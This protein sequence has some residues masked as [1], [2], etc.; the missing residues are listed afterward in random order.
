MTL[1]VV[2]GRALRVPDALPPEFSDEALALRFTA[3][4]RADLRHVA[5][6]GKW[7]IYQ[8]GQWRF[9][10][11]L[12][13]FSLARAICR[14]AAHGC[15]DRSAKAIASAKTVAAVEKLAKADRLH[16]AT[17]DQW[18]ADPWLL[19]T[20]GGVIDLRTG[21][22]QPHERQDYMTKITAA[23][24][25]GECPLWRA[26]LE[27][28]T[29]GD[30]EL[31]LFLQRVVGYALSGNTREH[32]LFFLY[33]T[34]ANGKSVFINTIAG[35]LGDYHTTA[36][37]DV[38]LES[39][40]KNDRHPTE[41]ACL[42]GARLVTATETEEGRRW[43][44]SRIKALTGGDRISAR[45]MRQDFFEFTPQFKLLVAGN[46]KPSLRSVDEAIRRRLHLIPFT[47]TIPKDE[48]DETLADK[49]KAE[50]PG[51]LAWAI[52]GGVEWGLQGLMPPEAVREATKQYLSAEDAMTLWIEECCKVDVD[53]TA[54]T[55]ELYKSWRQ[56]CDRTGE[57]AGSQKRFAQRLD[58][59]NYQRWRQGGT[60]RMGFWGLLPISEPDPGHS[61][62]WQ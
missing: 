50:W 7:L 31:E 40:T 25:E 48:R 27:R 58:D 45:F 47:V 30:T 54:T 51:I 57:F 55:A 20:P 10:A 49:L 9:D 43:A 21:D 46:H 19:N 13:A 2:E 8:N 33:G 4:H 38:F 12:E 1:D 52:E 11:T 6:W 3:R 24:P 22:H 59:R 17:V 37:M 42:R 36:S 15:N 61:K 16:A 56:W 53:Y 18:D 23:A 34:G 14:E 29:N 41:L 39:K 28:V 26:F 60:G 62:R 35:V 32:A 44:E 5:A